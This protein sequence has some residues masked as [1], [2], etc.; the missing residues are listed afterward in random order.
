MT[1][2]Y[3]IGGRFSRGG[4]RR[5]GRRGGSDE[6]ECREGKG[7]YV[8]ERLWG[9]SYKREGKGEFERGNGRQ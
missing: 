4:G 2:H 1:H 3:G 9:G 7:V 8:R 5:E 6:G